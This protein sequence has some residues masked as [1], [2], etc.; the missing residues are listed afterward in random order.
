MKKGHRIVITPSTAHV[1]VSLKGVV[2]AETKTPTILA[3]TGLPARY[4]IP[5]SDVRMELLRPSERHTTCPF[6]GEAS[7]WSVHVDGEALPDLVWSYPEPIPEAEQIGGLLC[8]YNEKVD[9]EV[10]G[11]LEAASS[12]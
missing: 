6:K 3:E 12:R 5:R 10:D 1:R 2:V 11:E 7:Y 9:L 8:F 4:Y